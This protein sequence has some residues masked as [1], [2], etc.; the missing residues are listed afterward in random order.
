MA[1][2]T[3]RPT[4]QNGATIATPA[5]AVAVLAPPRLAPPAD[6]ILQKYEVD[7]EGW[8]TLTESIFPAAKS[9]TSVMMALE[10]CARRKLDVFKH[11]VHIVPIWNAQAGENGRGAMVETI[12]PGINELRTTAIRTGQYAGMDVPTFGPIIERHFEGS[13]RTRG[14]GGDQWKK[15]E[16]TVQFPEWCSI[17]VYR[18][19]GGNRVPFPGPRVFWLETYAR[20]RNDCEVPNS[21]WEKRANGQ[22]EKCAEAAALRRAFPEELGSDYSIDEIGAF[23]THAPTDVTGESS[24]TTEPPPPEPKAKDFQEPS[25]GGKAAPKKRSPRNKSGAATSLSPESPTSG[26]GQAGGAAPP[27]AGGEGSTSSGQPAP[28]TD[29]EDQNAPIEFPEFTRMTEFID[30]SSDWLAKPER[31]PAHAKLWEEKFHEQIEKAAKSDIKRIKD[32]I[33][34][35]LAVYGEVLAKEPREPG[36]EG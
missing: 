29:V 21:M 4:Q 19:L 5:Q 16:A 31:T 25:T 27:A 34:D 7:I 18:V 20:I 9:Q 3:T 12:W 17:T 26:S 36:A 28:V 33:T 1:Q 6:G 8:R 2:T 35:I 24:A 32:G 15:V 22:L 13:I 10:Y 11:P 14:Q 30:F 23:T